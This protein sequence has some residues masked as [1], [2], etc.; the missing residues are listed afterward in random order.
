MAASPTIESESVSRV[1][2]S[3]ATLEA[4]LNT[5]AV[6]KPYAYYQFELATS[7][8]ELA[9]EFTCPT[10]DDSSFCLGVPEQQGSL[11]I[12]SAEYGKSGV[13]VTLAVASAG[14]PLSPETTYY[15]RVVAAQAVR[16]E[17]TREWVKPAVDGPTLSFTTPAPL[18]PVQW[19]VDGIKAPEGKTYPSV[20]WGTLSLSNSNNA[21]T[22]L[23]CENAAIGEYKNPTGGGAGEG[24]TDLFAT[25]NCADTECPEEEGLE[26]QIHSED[27]PWPNV[28]VESGYENLLE[29]KGVEQIVGCYVA[30]TSELVAESTL[31]TGSWDP[32]LENGVAGQFSASKIIFTGQTDRLACTT[33]P[34]GVMSEGR[35]EKTLKTA[36]Y[37]TV[38]TKKVDIET[39]NA[40]GF[41][42]L[43]VKNP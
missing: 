13:L 4:H 22:P 24:E 43:E 41:E 8:S 1:I 6:E 26:L 28:L 14:R 25:T 31:C 19:Y 20:S 34:G 23:S 17:D 3:D 9:P 16:T 2:A 29:T 40:K 27:L 12:E 36:T 21:L 18:P 30:H 39:S 37:G 35:T 38:P 15:Y 11:P 7:P 32:H 5:V 33:E 42:L 10:G